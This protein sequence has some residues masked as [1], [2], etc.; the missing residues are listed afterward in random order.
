MAQKDLSV[1]KGPS[2]FSKN[3][4]N[5]YTTLEKAAKNKRKRFKWKS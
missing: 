4:K 1:F 5:W 3:I 2:S